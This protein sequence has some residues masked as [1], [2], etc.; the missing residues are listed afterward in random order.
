MA[1][2]GKIHKNSPPHPQSLSMVEKRNAAIKAVKGIGII[3]KANWLGCRE[4][5]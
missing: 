5:G 2:G 3:K 1:K 4:A